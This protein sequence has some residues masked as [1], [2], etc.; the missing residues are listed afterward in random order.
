VVNFTP[1]K[2]LTRWLGGPWRQSGHLGQGKCSGDAG[3][4]TT[5]PPLSRR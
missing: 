4:R 3:N 1:G 5:I 2:V